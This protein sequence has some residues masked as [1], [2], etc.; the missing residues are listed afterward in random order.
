MPC[1]ILATPREVGRFAPFLRGKL[2][3]PEAM[4][5]RFPQQR[6]LS[7]LCPGR[8]G[9]AVVSPGDGQCVFLCLGQWAGSTELIVTPR[10]VGT[11]AEEKWDRAKD[12]SRGV[13]TEHPDLS[14]GYTERLSALRP[15]LAL[16]KALRAPWRAR[17][18]S[19]SPGRSEC[20]LSGLDVFPRRVGGP[21]DSWKAPPTVSPGGH[22]GCG[23]GGLRVP[24]GLQELR[25]S[26]R[27]SGTGKPTVWAAGSRA[28]R[29]CTSCP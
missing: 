5:G 17:S 11:L 7:Q 21:G 13:Q 22:T 12:L 16:G 1:S 24:T 20:L 18:G 15:E 25:V 2:P 19:G 26:W 3:G 6:E 28:L 8:W 14:D 10:E 23:G 4:E 9:G 27:D 29:I